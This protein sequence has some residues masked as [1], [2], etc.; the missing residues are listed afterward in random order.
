MEGGQSVK[1][2]SEVTHKLLFALGENK[3]CELQLD[4]YRG[5]ITALGFPKLYK[6]FAKVVKV[7]PPP[8]P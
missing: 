7:T 6:K 8:S 2:P 3:D 1:L 5:R 4:R